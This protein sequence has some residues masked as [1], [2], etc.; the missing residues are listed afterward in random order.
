VLRARLREWGTAPEDM[1]DDLYQFA[2]QYRAMSASLSSRLSDPGIGE[3]AAN[4]K[5]MLD[6][7][8]VPGAIQ[9]LTRTGETG[10]ES[11]REAR[12]QADEQLRAAAGAHVLAGDLYLAQEAWNDAVHAYRNAINVFPPT[13][14]RLLADCLSKLGTASYR[15]G[16]MVAAE[17]AFH[18][19]IQVLEKL[20]GP[21]H[22]D[23]AAQLNNLGLMFFQKDDMDTAEPLYRRALEID[24]KA[25]GK[26][27]ATVATDLN[28]LAL[29]YKRKG[30]L[31]A[32]EPL[33]K[34][35]I[36][37]KERMLAGDDPSLITGLKN[38]A[39]LL[40]ALN[41]TAEARVLEARIGEAA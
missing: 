19:A 25:L 16:D 17:K 32:A 41:R 14:K 22:E 27:H 1:D 30:D 11:G 21:D 40:R 28:N 5:A 23:V 10:A 31:A 20:L 4:A 33:M 36:F 8:D 9:Y 12:K 39:A 38:Y 6:T 34:R 18:H 24:E 26:N 35:S 29:L 37:I 2:V 3:T 15:S 7:G 13:A